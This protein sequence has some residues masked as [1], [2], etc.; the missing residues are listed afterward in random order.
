MTVF[1]DTSVP[2]AFLDQSQA[3]HRD[4]V[5]A[6]SRTLARGDLLLTSNYVAVET[7]ALVQR[8][9]GLRA[10]HIL[11]NPLFP[12][13]E[14]VWID[15]EQHSVATAAVLSAGRRKLSIVDC[16][17]FELMRRR[18]IRTVLSLDSDF[19]DQGFRLIPS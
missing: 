16:T 10:V 6:W 19:G 17:S 8:R 2:V 9:L 12:L 3:R 13:I 14:R 18:G 15:E 11:V 5:A 7:F 1:V 4:V